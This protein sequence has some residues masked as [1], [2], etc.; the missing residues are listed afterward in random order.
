MP[1]GRLANGSSGRAAAVPF[2]TW[3]AGT[4]SRGIG[5]VRVV[6]DGVILEALPW[7]TGAFAHQ[8]GRAWT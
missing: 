1:P 6:V 2:E 4:E 5:N 7:S 3:S 8:R